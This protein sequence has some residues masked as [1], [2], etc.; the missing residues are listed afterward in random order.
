MLNRYCFSILLIVVLLSI[1]CFS[2]GAIDICLPLN[3]YNY[4]KQFYSNLEGTYWRWKN[5]NG[6]V[7]NFTIPQSQDPCL[8][9]WQG[10][11]C[12]NYTANECHISSIIL[13]SSNLIGTIPS[14]MSALSRLSILTLNDNGIRGTIPSDLHKVKS[15]QMVELGYNKLTGSIPSSLGAL[16]NLTFFRARFNSLN[17][18]IPLELGQLKELSNLNLRSNMLSG[19]L[20]STIGNM[21]KMTILGLFINRF[22]G[23]I[24]ITLSKLSLVIHIFLLL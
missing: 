18:T 24:P 22:T 8:L 11:T 23:K 15:L 9:R 14:G 4:L 5:S 3:E 7:W 13:P 21:T 1:L 17:G 19:P 16:S 20:P 6:A 12:I 10:L 2:A